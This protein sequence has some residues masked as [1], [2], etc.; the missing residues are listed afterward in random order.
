MKKKSSIKYLGMLCLSF[1]LI[2]T[3]LP[4]MYLHVNAEDTAR[5]V[6]TYDELLEAINDSSVYHIIVTDSIDVPC[7]Y[8]ANVRVAD[9][10]ETAQLHIVSDKF[11]EGVSRDIVIRRISDSTSKTDRKSLFEIHG[12]EVTFNNITL[13][14]GS[15]ED[16][17]GRA[18]IDICKYGTLNVENTTIRNGWTTNSISSHAL[19][20]GS[21]NYGGGIRVDSNSTSDMQGGTINLKLGSVIEN[22]AASSKKDG[23]S[24][25]GVGGGIGVYNY[26]Y[27]NMYGGT[28]RNC[29]ANHGGG[30]GGTCRSGRNGEYPPTFAIYGGTIENCKAGY[31]GAFYLD[32]F[33]G[34]LKYGYD[35]IESAIYGLTI[36]NCTASNYGK[37]IYL[38]DKYTL[39]LDKDLCID[40]NAIDDDDAIAKAKTS[41]YIFV[42][43][44]NAKLQS[45]MSKKVA[46]YKGDQI[47]AMLFADEGATLGDAFPLDLPDYGDHTFIG[48]YTKDE[49]SVRAEK[50]TADTVIDEG[51]KV[52]ATYE[53]HTGGKAKCILPA[54]CEV[55]NDTYG[56]INIANHVDTENKD[57]IEATCLEDGYS[58][59]TYCVD[60]HEKLYDGYTVEKLGHKFVDGICERCND[61]WQKTID[62]VYYSILPDS[63]SSEYMGICM[64][65]GHVAAMVMAVDGEL[66]GTVEIIDIIEDTES[67]QL[68][69]VTEIIKQAFE[70]TKVEKVIVPGSVVRLG[71]NAFKGV[72]EIYFKGENPPAGIKEAI[73]EDAIIYVPEGCKDAYEAALGLDIQLIEVHIHTFASEYTYDSEYHWHDALCGHD[74][75]IEKEAHIF[76]AWSVITEPTEDQEGLKERACL[77]GYKDQAIIEKLPHKIHVSDEGSIKEATCIEDGL[78]TYKC[79]KCGDVINTVVIPAT[80]HVWDMGQITKAPTVTE[81]GELTYKCKKCDAVKT[82]IID[83]LPEA[84]KPVE[85]DPDEQNKII[86]VPVS[87]KLDLIP[88]IRNML[89]D[90]EYANASIDKYVLSDKSLAKVSKN[91]IFVAKK[92]GELNITVSTKV[93]KK[94]YKEIGT[95]ELKIKKVDFE[96]KV[97]I[98]YLEDKVC[99]L[100][101][102]KN[103]PSGYDVT[104]TMPEKM[105]KYASLDEAT[106]FIEPVQNGK[107]KVTCNIGDG[108]TQVKYNCVVTIKTPLFAVSKDVKMKTGASKTLA[109]KN[110][111]AGVD[112]MWLSSDAN[113]IKIVNE[114][115]KKVKIQAVN[116]GEAYITCVI[117]GHKIMKKIIVQ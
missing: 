34:S 65:N 86:E 75:V 57:A 6:S 44:S 18:M 37:A 26:A 52:Y 41:Q 114:N 93:N 46:F 60:C 103:V 28:I 80:G 31:G 109:V 117:D 51:K 76:D 48:W 8:I 62:G 13:D 98:D 96:K 33:T 95:I 12:C 29:Y 30:I 97:S 11:I 23:V 81:E 53:G 55:C 17:R 14:G 2:M 69:E 27:V 67:K 38:K 105:K 64:D 68:F 39:L 85:V 10:K 36:N 66:E 90:T 77:C 42:S 49:H 16:V 83:K 79:S 19:D 110:V 20:Q 73:D 108:F 78:V 59:D 58:G 94:E 5:K 84:D 112:V 32:G 7:E 106:G 61:S 92:P 35:N 82:E 47:Y 116:A 113:I 71:E 104:F 50:I 40:S 102:L 88:I 87:G 1:I 22:C 21:W 43:G 99:L 25:D 115:A 107:I 111:K 4:N 9:G 72:K 70:N 24:G 74:D 3:M 54:I 63:E 89:N 56:D 101:Y 100:D 91:G 45:V 15:A